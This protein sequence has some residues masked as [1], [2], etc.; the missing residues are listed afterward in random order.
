[1]YDFAVAV[2]LCGQ[3]AGLNFSA[4]ICDADFFSASLLLGKMEMLGSS[5]SGILPLVCGSIGGLILS[6]DV[7]PNQSGASELVEPVGGLAIVYRASPEQY[8]KGRLAE[9]DDH[10]LVARTLMG[11][12]L[13]FEVLMDRYTPMVVGYLFGKTN[14]EGDAEDLG[15]EIFLTAFRNL[16]ALHSHDRFRFV[17]HADRADQ[18]N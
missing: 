11:D 12:D 16:T 8:A 7:V 14:G 6:A 9:L 15:Q 3:G 17:D 1:M 2:F 5:V 13:A 18:I 4:K 10:N